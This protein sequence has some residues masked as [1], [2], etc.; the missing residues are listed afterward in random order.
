MELVRPTEV[1][2]ESY[3]EALKR[4]WSFFPEGELEE[5]ALD[6]AS[7]LQRLDDPRGTGRPVIMPD[8][9]AVPRIPGYKRWMWDGDFAGVIAFRWQPGTPELPPHCLGHIGYGVVP[10]KRR[11]GYATLALRLMLP[12]AKAQGLPYVEIVT[13]ADNIASQ[14]VIVANGGVLVEHFRKGP[15]HFGGEAY[16]FQIDLRRLEAD[17]RPS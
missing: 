12:E 14:H 3:V 17:H 4:G 16:R 13:D 15:E 9:S 8:G 2:L 1:H 7:F 6:P 10:W 11:R 5:I